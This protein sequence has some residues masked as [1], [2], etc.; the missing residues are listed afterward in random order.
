MKSLAVKIVRTHGASAM[1][2]NYA[3]TED[4]NEMND[5]FS[6]SDNMDQQLLNS[7]E[8]YVQQN[9]NRGTINLED[10]AQ[11]MGMSMKPFFQKVHDL[12]GKTPAE[13]VRDLRLRHACILLQ[14]TNINMNELATHVGFAT[15]DYFIN[16]FKERFG[17]TPSEYR[18]N[19]R[20]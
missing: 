1:E 18:L 6:M 15:G 19:Y 7:I 10:M 12:T 13:V 4:I 2:Q 11:S 20:R 5:K 8:Q 14:R 16:L 9:M 17:M 3:F